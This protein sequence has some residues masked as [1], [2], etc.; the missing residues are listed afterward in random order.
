MCL[1]CQYNVDLHTHAHSKPLVMYYEM[2]A[3]M[4]IKCVVE[5]GMLKDGKLAGLVIYVLLQP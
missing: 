2:F 5:T 3:C 4:H 1:H